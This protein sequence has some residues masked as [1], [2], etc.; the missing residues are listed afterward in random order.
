MPCTSHSPSGPSEGAVVYSWPRPGAL[1]LQGNSESADQRPSLCPSATV[2]YNP[3]KNY[4]SAW[5]KNAQT[6]Y[7]HNPGRWVNKQ[8]SEACRSVPS[9]PR[10]L[11]QMWFPLGLSPWKL[12]PSPAPAQ[13]GQGSQHAGPSP[14]PLW[15][16]CLRLSNGITGVL[17]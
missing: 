3:W 6:S 8:I 9:A 7:P 11:V 4:P 5:M 16:S 2:K 14:K 1:M 15:H 12:F 10:K 13:A 17:F